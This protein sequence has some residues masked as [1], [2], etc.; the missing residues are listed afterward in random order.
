MA[1]DFNS[2]VQLREYLEERVLGFMTVDA[3]RE[4]SAQA[5]RL[6]REEHAPPVT[7]GSFG[8]I[9]PVV[10]WVIRSEDLNALDALVKGIEAGV[11]SGILFG[12]Q[13]HASVTSSIVGVLTAVLK[14][15]Q[16]ASAKGRVL[17]P[18][19]YSILVAL[20]AQDGTSRDALAATLAKI[21]PGCS[22]EEIE[23][24]V[25]ELQAM[26]VGDGTVLNFISRDANGLLRAAGV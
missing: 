13:T 6:F 15:G 21:G 18:L 16:R 11:A 5:A 14:L 1:I 10:R 8:L 7:E 4:F 23:H 17:N 19:Q 22:N 25:E 26:A 20:K 3:A 24:A 2:G 12:A 9:V